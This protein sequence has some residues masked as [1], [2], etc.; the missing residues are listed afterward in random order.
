M[1]A[2]VVV[3]H[4]D[5]S[6][7]GDLVKALDRA[8]Y[9]VAAFPDTLGA[10]AAITADERVAMMITRVTFPEGT[11]HGVSLALMA[12]LKRPNLIILFIARPEMVEHAEGVG[13]IL[14]TPALAED[15]V[16]K[17]REMLPLSD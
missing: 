7:L 11:P 5:A 6:F 3:V 1:P 9:E 16:A 8:G 4:D 17:V 15:V 2:R 12:R 14:H 13:E 10:L